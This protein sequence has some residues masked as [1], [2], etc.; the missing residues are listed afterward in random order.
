MSEADAAR[1]YSQQRASGPTA[2]NSALNMAGDGAMMSGNPY[3]MGAGLVL[4]GTAMVDDAKRRQ[5][6]AA[7]DAYNNKIMFYRDGIRN[8]FG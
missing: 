4:K 7:I 3:V 5:E 1:A 2:E 8:L 6:Q